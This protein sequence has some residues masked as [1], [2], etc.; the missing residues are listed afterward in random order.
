MIDIAT[1]GTETMHAR[2]EPGDTPASL[3][4]RHGANGWVYIEPANEINGKCF[5]RYEYATMAREA[6]VQQKT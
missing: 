6:P 3:E 4:A 5:V 2:V 1:A